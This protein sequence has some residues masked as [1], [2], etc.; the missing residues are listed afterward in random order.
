MYQLK[1]K[2]GPELALLERD[3]LNIGRDDGNDVVL[4]DDRVSGFH[5]AIIREGEA[6]ELVDLGSTNGTLINGKPIHGRYSLKAW[7]IISFAGLEVEV[8]DTEGR[9]PTLVQVA[10]TDQVINNYQQQGNKQEQPALKLVSDHGARCP[11]Q[12]SLS[13]SVTIGRTPDNDITLP[14]STISSQHARLEVSATCVE[15]IDS[16]STNGT[17]VNGQRV[18][19]QALHHG[20]R[21]RF[22]MVEYELTIPGAQASSSQTVVRPAVNS[23]QVNPA[24]KAAQTAP[25]AK[26]PVEK[27][28]DKI[29]HSIEEIRRQI[30]ERDSGSQPTAESKPASEAPT[31]LENLMPN[32]R[33]SS[34]AATQTGPAVAPQAPNA[35]Q[36]PSQNRQA[37]TRN[38]IP[39][40]QYGLKWLLFSFQGRL[41]RLQY[42]FTLLSMQV[43]SILVS[44]MIGA[45]SGASAT[46]IY[47]S[48]GNLG[49]SQGS[50]AFFGILSLVFSAISIWVGLAVAY[51]RNSDIGTPFAAIVIAALVA[52]GLG[53]GG[54]SSGNQALLVVAAIIGVSNGLYLLFAPGTPSGKANPHGPVRDRIFR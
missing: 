15:V 39:D 4:E 16:G 23:T 44:V 36:R 28:P 46:A 11:Q 33:V 54:F 1:Q 19:K 40:D 3:R 2:S 9:R 30:A 18:Y 8:I 10:L 52:G 41:T 7:D 49:A 13:R 17:W 43:V 20:D 22:D 24:L 21:V 38:R 5:A 29:N 6:F 53:W 51:K 42:F 25:S 26:P 48:S 47:Q 14:E 31:R 34:S 45:L 50:V 27:T 37:S 12:L 32:G 35:P